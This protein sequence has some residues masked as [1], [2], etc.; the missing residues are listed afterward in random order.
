MAHAQ[1]LGVPDH[2]IQRRAQ[3]MTHV[4]QKCGLGPAGRLG[5][6]SFMISS[7][8]SEFLGNYASGC[9]LVGS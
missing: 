8:Q 6:I 7:F 9:L 3:P 4:G 5:P 1:H 2:G